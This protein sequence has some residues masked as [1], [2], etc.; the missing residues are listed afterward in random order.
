MGCGAAECS[1][2]QRSEWE[3][4]EGG[5]GG[6]GW[7]EG[8]EGGREEGDWKGQAGSQG[9]VLARRGARGLPTARNLVLNPNPSLL[10]R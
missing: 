7:R 5:D 8:M 10:K 3:G 4:M 9:L 1:V 6:R 2:A